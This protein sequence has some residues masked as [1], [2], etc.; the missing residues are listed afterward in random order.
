MGSVEWNKKEELVAEQAL[1]HLK[2]RRL[3]CVSHNIILQRVGLVS[4]APTLFICQ[5]TH[6]YNSTIISFNIGQHVHMAW[7]LQPPFTGF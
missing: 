7:Q 1:K 3:Q 5:L 4:F 6:R 2:V